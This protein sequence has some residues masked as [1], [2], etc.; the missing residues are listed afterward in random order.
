MKSAGLRNGKLTFWLGKKA[1]SYAHPRRWR[2]YGWLG[3][4]RWLGAVA[5]HARFLVRDE[6][7]GSSEWQ[8]NFLVMQKK[9]IPTRIL[10][11]GATTDGSE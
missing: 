1:D 5:L 8:A 3:M 10:V 6:K 11:A 4:T 2:D 7:R 9:Q